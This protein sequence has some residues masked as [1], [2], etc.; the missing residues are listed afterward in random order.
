MISVI[1]RLTDRYLGP[2]RT[3]S[4]PP[5]DEDNNEG[6]PGADS[7]L[8]PNP[9]VSTCNEHTHLFSV[10]DVFSFLN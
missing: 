8:K 7:V 10:G 4:L 2:L 9:H 6:Q 1:T 5:D 3:L